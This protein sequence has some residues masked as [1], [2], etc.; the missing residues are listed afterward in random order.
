[1]NPARRTDGVASGGKLAQG[2]ERFVT[3][4]FWI[5]KKSP[6]ALFADISFVAG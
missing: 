3:A 5:G 6:A 4:T 1:L 2:S